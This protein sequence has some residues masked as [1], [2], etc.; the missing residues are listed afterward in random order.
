VK[1][2]L[3][4]GMSGTGKSTLI[5]ELAARGWRAVDADEAGWSAVRTLP[6]GSGVEQLWC[7]ERIQALLDRDDAE[8]VYVSG[9]A[10]NQVRFYARFDSIVLLSAPTEVMLERLARRTN[11]P[12]GKR[13]D[14]VALILEQ[15]RTIEPLL[16]RSAHLELDTSAPVA[17]LVERLIALAQT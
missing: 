17:E 4:T 10:S 5:G 1:R 8:A 16:R 14:E 12:Y 2:I 3:L 7:E 15:K 13:A 9:C 6:D 11:N